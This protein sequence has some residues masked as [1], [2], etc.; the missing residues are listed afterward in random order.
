MA[1]AKDVFKVRLFVGDNQVA[2]SDDVKLWQ[3][4]FAAINRN[5]DSGTTSD[6]LRLNDNILSGTSQIQEP[7]IKFAKEIGIDVS[8]LQIAC[9]PILKEPFMHLDMRC[10]AEWV[11]NVPTRGPTAV[12][13]FALSATLLCLWFRSAGLENPTMQQCQTILSAIGLEGKNPT[14]SIKNCPWLQSRRGQILQLKP[15]E[16]DKAVEVAKAFCEK[17]SPNL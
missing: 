7:V 10:W 14:R 13:A 11:K 1:V 5:E 3:S 8:M 16:I 15:A 9:D 2:E 17:N 12:S 6:S 4:V